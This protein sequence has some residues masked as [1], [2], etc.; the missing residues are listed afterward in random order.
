[1]KEAEFN[2]LLPFL[3]QKRITLS[4]LKLNILYEVNFFI[5]FH[6]LTL[7]ENDDISIKYHIVF[8]WKLIEVLYFNNIYNKILI[9]S[10]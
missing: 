3:K 6:P 5:N 8:D 4:L 7:N 1:M 2:M 9:I 10:F